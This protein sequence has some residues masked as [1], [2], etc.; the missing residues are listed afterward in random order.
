MKLFRTLNSLAIVIVLGIF[1]SFSAFAAKQPWTKLT[2]VQQEALA[3]V[4]GEWDTMPERLQKRLLATTTK[5]PQFS[6]KQKQRFQTRLTEW[7]KL[8]P[9]QRNRAREK[10]KAYSKI[11]P[12]KREEMKRMVLQKEAEKMSAASGVAETPA[13]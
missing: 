13:K 3:P 11:P 10:Y 12:D 6:A 8:T 9:E 4:A 1:P 2:P 7:S 5:Y